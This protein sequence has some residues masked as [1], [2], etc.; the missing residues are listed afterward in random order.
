MNNK[1][2]NNNIN[3]ITMQIEKNQS[4]NDELYNKIFHGKDIAHLIRM[5][6]EY[7]IKNMRKDF[8]YRQPKLVIIQVEGDKASNVYVNNKIKACEEVGIQCEHV[9]IKQSDLK[10]LRLASIAVNYIKRIVKERNEDNTV[11]G[12]IVQLPID[13]NSM[14]NSNNETPKLYY[15][16]LIDSI[17]DEIDPKK[18]VDGL[19]LKNAGKL[20]Q[21]RDGYYHVPATPLAIYTILRDY[22]K[23]NLKGKK[24]TI[25]GRSNL[26]GKPLFYLLSNKTKGNA[27]VTLLHSACEKEN[28]DEAIRNSDI[29]ICC[30]GNPNEYI[31]NKDNIKDGAIVIDAAINVKVDENGKRHLY[32][33]ADFVNIIDKCKFITPVPGGVGPMTVAM[34]L[35]NT[36]ESWSRNVISQPV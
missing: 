25:I 8:G 2:K 13:L 23:V 7:M 19:T 35:K 32:G 10:K 3:N 11:D 27:Q 6:L 15:N 26:L 12:I 34:L 22:W 14:F 28:I 24:I 18:D 30:A 1:N 36:F 31:V 9:F 20:A 5:Q 17:I 4:Q 16:N 33:D 29:V 21:D